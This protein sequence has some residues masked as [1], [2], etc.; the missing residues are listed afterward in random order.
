MEQK[1]KDKALPRQ[2][3]R[4]YS[5]V[6]LKTVCLDE[7]NFSEIWEF[8]KLVLLEKS[9]TGKLLGNTASFISATLG[10]SWLESSGCCNIRRV[11][12]DYLCQVLPNMYVQDDYKTEVYT[13][14]VDVPEFSILG[15]AWNEMYDRVLTLRSNRKLH[16]SCFVAVINRDVCDAGRSE[17]S[18]TK[19][20]CGWTETIDRAG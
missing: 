19:N 11:S 14:T 12:A 1:K 6:G 3:P 9:K 17:T 4:Q 5:P 2:K 16:K 18:V 13:R 15:S 20:K 7:G 8:Q 10:C